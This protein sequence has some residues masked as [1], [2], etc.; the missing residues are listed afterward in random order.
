MSPRK[1]QEVLEKVR[2]LL[3][4]FE[5]GK[6]PKLEIHEVHPELEIDSRENLLYFTLPVSIN[7]QRNS[8]AMWKSAL[9]T[10]EDPDTNYLFY[11]E[12]VVEKTLEQIKEDLPKHKLGLQKNKHSEIWYRLSGT[13]NRLYENN[14]RKLFEAND[15]DVLKILNILQKEMKKDFPYLSGIK[16]SNYWLFILSKFTDVKFKNLNYVSIIPDT[17][18]LQSS[19]Q[20]GLS[21]AKTTPAQVEL[22]WFELLKDSGIDPITMHPVLWNWSRNN[23]IPGF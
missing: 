15:F 5:N 10:F 18:V 2:M 8:P 4:N 21:D 12:K 20:L 13:F 9:A 14:P 19:I 16:I 7:F 3:E 6:I 17:H 22:I 11:P 1:K 23:F